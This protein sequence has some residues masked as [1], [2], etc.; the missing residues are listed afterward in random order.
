IDAPIEV[1]IRALGPGETRVNVPTCI[2]RI[3]W[4]WKSD[5][6]PSKA[7]S[8]HPSVQT[9]QLVEGG[10]QLCSIRRLAKRL[11]GKIPEPDEWARPGLPVLGIAACCLPQNRA[12]LVC[13]R[14]RKRALQFHEPLVHE[15][16]SLRVGQHTLSLFG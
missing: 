14:G 7:L 13:D 1:R 16:L 15:L 9:N 3:V 8:W 5:R 12:R 11:L 6:E 2:A 4:M 10:M